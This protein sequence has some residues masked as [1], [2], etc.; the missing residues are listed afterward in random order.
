MG[1]MGKK[2]SFLGKAWH[3]LWVEDS[4]LSWIVNL[5]LAFIIIKFVV[6]P[7]LGLAL[8]TEFPVVSVVSGSMEHKAVPVCERVGFGECAE[9]SKTKF[10][11]CGKEADEKGSLS[12]EKF[13]RY[14]GEWYEGKNISKEEF[15]SF[16]MSNG[17]NKGDI[18]F[19]KGKKFDDVKVGD[20]V[21]YQSGKPYPIIHR[22]VGKG[23]DKVMTKGDHNAEQIR[24][25]FLDETNVKKEQIYGVALF[26]IPYLGYPK[27]WLSRMFS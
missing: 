2:K 19:V 21:I 17:F 11:I 5:A 8:G 25:S 12:F 27:I 7:G 16:K 9:F 14:C 13:W 24:Q 1:V 10:G 20:I 6:Y 22:V 4:W 26:R 3:F 23:K 15:E 18:I